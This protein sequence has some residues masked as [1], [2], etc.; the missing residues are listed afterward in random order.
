M[1]TR[2]P[3]RNG[4]IEIAGKLY[5]PLALLNSGHVRH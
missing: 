1:P 2:V 3:F 4:P 5:P